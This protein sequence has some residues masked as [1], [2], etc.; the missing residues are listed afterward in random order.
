MRGL[1]KAF[2]LSQSLIPQ[3]I[4]VR[5]YHCLSL[6]DLS[7]LVGNPVDLMI[8]HLLRDSRLRIEWLLVVLNVLLLYGLQSILNPTFKL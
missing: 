3:S 7:V 5:G 8:L 4:I 2:R 1:L 6:F